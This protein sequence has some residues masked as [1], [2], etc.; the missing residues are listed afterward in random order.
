MRKT[1]LSLLLVPLYLAIWVG[2]VI[3]GHF[4]IPDI[5][6]PS[7]GGLLGA[8]G[9]AMVSII[10]LLIPWSQRWIDNWFRLH[11]GF[12][13]GDCRV[14]LV[15]A[16]GSGKKEFRYAFSPALLISEGQEKRQE[17]NTQW[18]GDH[19]LPEAVSRSGSRFLFYNYQGN[20]PSLLTVDRG[21]VTRI[22]DVLGPPNRRPVN[23]ILFFVDLFPLILGSEDKL[24]EDDE[25]V[26]SYALDATNQ[27]HVEQDHPDLDNPDLDNPD[28]ENP[29]QENPEQNSTDP[30]NAVQN[31]AGQATA[32]TPAPAARK[33]AKE[34][35]EERVK[36]HEV[37]LSPFT[38][39]QAFAFANVNEPLS[40]I[41][42]I[43]KKDLLRKVIE[44]DYLL[45]VTKSDST[46]MRNYA[47]TWF[48]S[49]IKDI[50][51]ACEVNGVPSFE[52][53]L[54]SSKNPGSL[55]P[56]VNSIKTRFFKP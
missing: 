51:E 1:D 24:Y 35:F 54:V 9:A 26:S 23:A 25:V 39:E 21:A 11:F 27:G 41:L 13:A 4:F 45:G 33:T 10:V 53:H 47:E 18:Y 14:L 8:I 7:I 20:K 5:P 46:A 40:V 56:V 15:G 50:K 17:D 49:I 31:V 37:Y 30:V 16:A 48:E 52:V 2:S 36:H 43:T 28:Q 12:H 29:D 3:A 44:A 32:A 19:L 38:I 22:S 55:V 42:V 6:G 34:K